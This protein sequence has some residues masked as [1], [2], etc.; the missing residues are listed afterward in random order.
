LPGLWAAQNRVHNEFVTVRSQHL[1]RG[2]TG[3]DLSLCGFIRF[4]DYTGVRRNTTDCLD[5]ELVITR[6][7]KLLNRNS[8][9]ST[10]IYS[11]LSTTKIR[12][13]RR[14]NDDGCRW[15]IDAASQEQYIFF[16]QP[17]L[18]RSR[19]KD[20]DFIETLFVELWFNCILSYILC[21]HIAFRFPHPV[22]FV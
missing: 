17:T 6:R 19:A 7:P 21:M 12:R 10:C 20:T 11:S 22:V 13:K 16:A 4:V 15:P 18:A 14:F 2:I 1:T 8:Y 5:A 9:S 3:I